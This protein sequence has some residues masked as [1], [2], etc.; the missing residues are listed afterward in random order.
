M[1]KDSVSMKKFRRR[2]KRVAA[3]EYKKRSQELTDLLKEGKITQKEFDGMHEML[4]DQ[5]RE[6]N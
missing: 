1:E 5:Y 2:D 6:L 3:Q 4:D